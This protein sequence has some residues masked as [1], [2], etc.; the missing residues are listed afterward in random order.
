[1]TSELGKKRFNEILGCL[2]YKPPGKPIL[3]PADD[4]RPEINIHTNDL[5]NDQEEKI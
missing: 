4:K 2:V 5:I 3:I 1:M